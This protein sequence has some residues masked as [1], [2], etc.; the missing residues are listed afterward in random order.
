MTRHDSR[1]LKSRLRRG[2]AASGKPSEAAVS[3]ARQM[4]VP[5][6]ASAAAGFRRNEIYNSELKALSHA[7]LEPVDAAARLRAAPRCGLSQIGVLGFLA[8]ALAIASMNG[9]AAQD[10]A[11]KTKS[12]A[13]AP[14]PPARPA[15]IGGAVVAGVPPLPATT[16]TLP[17]ASPEAQTPTSPQAQAPASPQGKAP[18]AQQTPDDVPLVLGATGPLPTASRQRMHACG[19]EWQAIKIA[20][21]AIDKT[22]RDFAE[23]CL[24]R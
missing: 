6:H 21:R 5:G 3:I 14:L 23:A 18:G 11:A 17:Q 20:G 15:K 4:P 8:A 9:A 10:P 19:L 24:S 22:W 2:R 7:V 16:P 13:A 1:L 12:A